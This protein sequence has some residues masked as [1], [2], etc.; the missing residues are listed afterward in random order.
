MSQSSDP[1][2]AV[3]KPPPR[4]GLTLAACALVLLLGAGL[5][6]IIFFTEPAAQRSGATKR[7]AMLVEVAEVRRGAY[8]PTIV[9]LG[10]VEPTRRVSLS[11]QVGGKIV[12]VAEV[13]T[14]GGFAEAGQFLLQI[15]SSDFENELAQR[16]S[17]LS[18]ANV[19]L[20]LELGRQEVAQLGNQALVQQGYP[21]FGEPLSPVNEALVLRQPQLEAA[22]ERV[23]A[24]KAAVEQAELNLRRA[25]LEAP[26]DAQILSRSANVGSL[27][28]PGDTLADLVGVDRYWVAATVPMAKLPWLDFANGESDRGSKARARNRA[29][30][31]EGQY[32]EGYLDT[33]VGA[34]EEETRLAKVLVVVPDPLARES[35]APPLLVGSYLETRLQ[36]R[37]LA[38]VVRLD[39][40]FV[41]KGDTAWIMKDGKL[42]IRELGIAFED[43]KFA[44]VS[45][46]LED[47]D[48]VVT[49]NLSTVVDGAPLRLEEEETSLAAAGG[50]PVE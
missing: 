24:A 43:E 3:S 37:E 17:D 40:D 10:V 42:R 6:A 46:G 49:T 38:N 15:D 23:A 29:S 11:P 47:G 45:S 14:P 1:S 2:K 22:R 50:D 4:K 34:L 44:Y 5:T 28:S 31:P 41:R 39:R 18:Q 8:R 25:R 27:A 16:R 35:D 20:M 9:A 36:G 13:F 21:Y 30:W 19:D 32:R 48:Q 26:F 7:T 12:E 33:L